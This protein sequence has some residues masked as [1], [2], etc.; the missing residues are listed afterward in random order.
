MR[1]A[2]TRL[3]HGLLTA[4]MATIVA[5]G[6]PVSGA[7]A[8]TIGP[9]G[10]AFYSPPSPLPDAPHGT[11]IW[12]R[13]ARVRL[14]G[15]PAASA[16]TV[17]YLS[18]SLAGE[19]DAVTGTV[20]VPTA[21]WSGSGPRPVLDYAVGTQGLDQASAP[22]LQLLAGSEYEEIGIDQALARGWA[23][24]VTDYAGYTNGATPDYIVGQ[25]EGHAIL[26][27][28][29]AALQI[30]GTGI[31]P[32]AP[33]VIWGY[34]QGGQ[35]SAWAAQLWPSYDPA[36]YLIG[37]ASGGVPSNLDT[38]AE[39]LNGHIGAPFLLFAAIGLNTDYPSLVDLDSYLNPAG[40]AA[41]DDA[42]TDGLLGDVRFIYKNIDA[43]TNGGETL[44]QLLAVP[45]IQEAI[46]AQTLGTVPIRVPMFHYHARSDEI[47]PF[48]QD[49]SLND[50]YCSLGDIVDWQTY[51]G[52]HLLGYLEGMPDALNWIASRFA[53]DLAPN[54]CASGSS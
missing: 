10:M 14:D 11:L 49:Q 20:L 16:W 35:A 1:R 39:L 26:D 51:P 31:S 27:I 22:S 38:T 9:S 19:P 18:Q 2:H 52:G 48:A 15:G 44:E 21:A 37:D 25:S 42:E 40:L 13:P 46:Q 34:S 47:I 7:A 28:D 41:V 24:E 30:P 53:G 5:S 45:S 23:V 50:T 8:A 43:Y 29:T 12:Y 17:L 36:M 4:A 3:V 33:H 54:N 6:L 32:S